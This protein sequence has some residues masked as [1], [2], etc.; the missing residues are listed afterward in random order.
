[1]PRT[2]TE[3]FAMDFVAFTTALFLGLCCG[4]AIAWLTA[5]SQGS[6]M[7]S[8]SAMQMAALRARL[9]E[10]SRRV[11]RLEEELRARTEALETLRGRLAV[12]RTSRERLTAK[13]G[14]EH[15]L[16]ERFTRLRTDLNA[17]LEAYLQA[18]SSMEDYGMEVA[19]SLVDL[20]PGASAP[21]VPDDPPTPPLPS[22]PES[23]PELPPL[24][25]SSPE[26]KPDA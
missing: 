13:L 19:Q 18:A 6:S 15:M 23:S 4:V 11:D 8:E 24:Q 21:E 3:G 22:P 26:E 20:D 9:D 10:R 12:L 17:A 7:A 25:E 2:F 16:A 1:M 14:A 5:R